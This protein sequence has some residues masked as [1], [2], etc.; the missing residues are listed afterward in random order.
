MLYSLCLG[1]QHGNID[2]KELL[3]S[4]QT[5][6]R[7]VDDIAAKYRSDLKNELSEP[8]KAKSIT[9]SP[10]FWS[11]KYNQQSYLGLNI[12]FV[13]A[14]HE[15]K[16]IDLFCVP[17]TGVKSYDLILDVRNTKCFM[18]NILLFVIGSSRPILSWTYFLYF[19]RLF[20]DNYQFMV[21]LIYQN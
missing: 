19:R 20:D 2:V 4:R 6:A 14:N 7:S 11:N 18:H 9:I 16:S 1:A 5:V 10:D 15:F 12:T 21:S 8:F 13:N 3:R 17:V